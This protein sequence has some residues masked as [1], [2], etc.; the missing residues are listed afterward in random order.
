ML[1]IC[2]VE[3][4]V[5]VQ[6]CNTGIKLQEW[7]LREIT[8]HGMMRSRILLSHVPEKDTAC[9]NKR[10]PLGGESVFI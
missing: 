9:I 5:Q 4:W 1:L 8:W 10:L 3:G 2:L 7:F 6:H